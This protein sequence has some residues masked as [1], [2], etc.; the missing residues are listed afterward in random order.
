MCLMLWPYGVLRCA[1]CYIITYIPSPNHSSQY[2]SKE[3][4]SL[5]N[6][7]AIVLMHMFL[8]FPI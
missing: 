8:P 7:Y 4:A 1:M 6:L 3:P 5:C 2:H